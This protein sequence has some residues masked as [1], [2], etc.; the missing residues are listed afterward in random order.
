MNS[1][2]ARK[3]TTVPVVTEYSKDFP[4]LK[5]N[6]DREV[7]CRRGSTDDYWLLMNQMYNYVVWY[8]EAYNNKHKTFLRCGFTADT[9][10]VGDID[11]PIHVDIKFA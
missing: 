3:I 8:I 5:Q 6:I 1:T 9:I 2:S 4:E 11:R 10:W 7:Y